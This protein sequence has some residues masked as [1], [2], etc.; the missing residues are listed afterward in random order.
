[1]QY[2][3]S[4]YL[5]SKSVVVKNS[6]VNK[7]NKKTGRANNRI[8]VQQMQLTSRSCLFLNEMQQEL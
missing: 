3:N 7:V 4:D 1:M 6:Q 8:N 5:C 2:I